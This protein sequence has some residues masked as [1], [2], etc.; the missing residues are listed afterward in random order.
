[1][2]IAGRCILEKS[3]V[4]VEQR[5]TLLIRRALPA[6]VPQPYTFL[7]VDL[8]PEGTA[9]LA[10]TLSRRFPG[11]VIIT[12]AE[13]DDSIQKAR[14]QKPD[15]IVVHRP[16]AITGEEMVRQL[17]DA[18]PEVPIIMVSSA[19]KTE[20]ARNAGA[21]GFLLYDA[22]LLLGGVVADHLKETGSRKPWA[23]AESAAV[24][25]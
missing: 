18:Q 16:L 6:P 1:L 20:S 4:M 12:C 19:E 3:S 21:D 22:W 17:R 9:L 2:K 11:A 10:R 8:N 13:A 23:D 15:A 25:D 5:R 24:H 14:T 7:V